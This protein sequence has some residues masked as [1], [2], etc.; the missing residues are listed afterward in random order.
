MNALWH[1]TMVEIVKKQGWRTYGTC[2]E[3][4]TQ[5]PLLGHAE[6]NM[7]GSGDDLVFVFLEN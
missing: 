4:G 6:K 5:S 2:A 1:K 7:F 3:G